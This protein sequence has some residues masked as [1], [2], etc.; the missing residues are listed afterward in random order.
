MSVTV[1]DASALTSVLLDE[2]TAGNIKALLA[3]QELA[4]P[5]LLP[6][7]IAN[8]CAIKNTAIS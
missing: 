4:A 5:A 6:F 7:E 2:A 1:V 8:V 3:G